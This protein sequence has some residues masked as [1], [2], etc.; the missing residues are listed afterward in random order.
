[1]YSLNIPVPGYISERAWE[2]RSRLTGFEEL[3]DRH[4]LVVKRLEVTTREEYLER[5]RSVRDVVR[6][7][8][9]F[10][11]RVTGIDTFASPPAGR[12]P[13]VYFVVE[14][15]GL[16]ALHGQLV[17]AFGAVSGIEGNRYEPHIT[18]ARGGDAGS[19]AALDEIEISPFSWTVERLIFW[20]ATRQL[21]A[22]DIRLP[23]R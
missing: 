22:G 21:P 11:A 23:A 3:R 19:I 10:E 17:D 8:V 12:A 2:L 14:S 18:L 16:V 6:D 15:P 13:V 9:P 5:E 20:D 4:T 1:M 7:T